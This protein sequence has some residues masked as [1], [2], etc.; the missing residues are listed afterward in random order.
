[1]VGLRTF[2][3]FLPTL[4]AAASIQTGF[5]WGAVGFTTLILL[6]SVVRRLIGRLEL[7]HS[8]QLAVMLTVAISA[9]L[10]TAFLADAW[11]F[12]K[13]ARISLFPVAILA[14]TAERFT[15]L[16]M[17]DGPLAAWQTLAL[18]LLVVFF[19]WVTMSSLS[20]QIL[21]LAFPELLLVVMAMDIWLGRWMGLR[22]SEWARFRVL[23]WTGKAA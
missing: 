16:E 9:M 5:I 20:L 11:G 22:L 8:P 17:E 23:I 4:I 7:L 21:M 15:L 14:I 2:G 6:G 1:V 3:T 19:C 10:M 12:A 13:L 18:T